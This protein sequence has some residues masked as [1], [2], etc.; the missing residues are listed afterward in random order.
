MLKCHSGREVFTMRIYLMQHGKPVAKEEDPERPLSQK[1]REEVSRI[2][3]A[4][5]KSGMQVSQALHSGKKRA[6]Q[7]AEIMLS[8][9]NP[10]GKLVLNESISPLDDPKK[11]ASELSSI[12][13]DTLVVGHLPHLAKLV[14]LLV[15][16][17]QERPVV[18]FQQGGIVCL[19]TDE[20][21]GQWAVAWMVVPQLLGLG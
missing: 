17:D 4:L 10:G 11:I 3:E 7:T 5:K 13:E 6:E 1:G 12:S 19:E 18:R 14:S 8:K 16:G 2:A 20:Q 15:T 21:K 9:L